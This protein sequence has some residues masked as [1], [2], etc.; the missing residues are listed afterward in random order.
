MATS[1]SDADKGIFHPVSMPK[2]HGHPTLVYVSTRSELNTRMAMVLKARFSEALSS[3]G[4]SVQ[5]CK[6]SMYIYTYGGDLSKQL[7]TLVPSSVHG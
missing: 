4:Y 5:L 3:Q 2:V 6:P 7:T 1:T